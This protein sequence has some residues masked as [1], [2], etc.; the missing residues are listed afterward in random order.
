MVQNGTS[1]L[2]MGLGKRVELDRKRARRAAVRGVGTLVETEAS[3]I[4]IDVSLTLGM[5]GG[6]SL[7]AVTESALLILY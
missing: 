6:G 3:F 2:L 1:V 7:W 5:L 4:G